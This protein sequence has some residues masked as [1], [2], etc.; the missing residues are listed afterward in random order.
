MDRKERKFL[1]FRQ[2]TENLPC[3]A[4]ETECPYIVTL[5]RQDLATA[6]RPGRIT[7]RV[8]PTRRLHRTDFEYA[9]NLASVP[10]TALVVG[11]KVTFFDET[12]VVCGTFPCPHNKR[13]YAQ[14]TYDEYGNRVQTVSHGDQDSPD[15]ETTTVWT[16]RP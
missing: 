9:T 14:H 4:G 3:I 11:E 12:G 1:G 7:S 16:F 2:M 8:G 15:D 5:L 6:G 10:M 13:R